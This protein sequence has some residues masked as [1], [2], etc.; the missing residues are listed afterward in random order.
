[1]T[2][3]LR[4]PTVDVLKISRHSAQLGLGGWGHT[5]IPG[6]FIAHTQILGRFSCTRKNSSKKFFAKIFHTR[7]LGRFSCTHEIP[8]VFR[9]LEKI[10]VKKFFAKIFYTR[11]LGRFSCTHEIPAVFQKSMI[12]REN[13]ENSTISCVE[14]LGVL[15]RETSI[16]ASTIPVGPRYLVDPASGDM[17][18]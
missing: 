9:A 14:C 7:I 18:R 6:R 11:I 4:S 5:R 1:M 12:L 16:F 2:L 10:Q 17:L 15:A 13:F 3:R 8:A